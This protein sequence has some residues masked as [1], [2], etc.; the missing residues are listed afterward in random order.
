M[1]PPTS[2]VVAALHRAAPG[3][4]FMTSPAQM[5]GYESDGLGYKS[6]RPDL[7][8]IP[9]DANELAQVVRV[10]HEARVPT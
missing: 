9:S 6:F 3:S 10:V 7:V 4:Q 5:A 2:T 1:T 8:V